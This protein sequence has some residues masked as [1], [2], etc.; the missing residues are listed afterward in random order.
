MAINRKKL[1]NFK[2][3]LHYSHVFFRMHQYPKYFTLA[4]GAVLNLIHPVE[5][6]AT[7]IKNTGCTKIRKS[8]TQEPCQDANEP[9]CKT[10]KNII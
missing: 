6:F 7:A 10:E 5:L 1:H 2:K 3:V 9:Y 4:S 8:D